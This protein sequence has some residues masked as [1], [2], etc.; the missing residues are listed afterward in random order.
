M[1]LPLDAKAKKWVQEYWKKRPKH[2]I[3]FLIWFPCSNACQH[4][5]C[6]IAAV[7]MM[8]ELYLILDDFMKVK[9]GHR[10]L[11]DLS[12]EWVW[13]KYYHHSKLV[14][15]ASAAM[16][17]AVIKQVAT[18]WSVWNVSHLSSSLLGLPRSNLRTFV[19]IRF[20]FRFNSC[21]LGNVP[22]TSIYIAFHNVG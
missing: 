13:G 22:W 20:N 1:K 14:H 8:S 12:D 17:L 3:M 15:H 2:C 10:L 11:R 5:H 4:Y 18:R 19:N 16:C 7:V 6:I 21:T 9:E